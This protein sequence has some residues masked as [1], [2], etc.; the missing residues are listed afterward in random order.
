[1]IPAQI[2]TDGH[3]PAW[4]TLPYHVLLQIF[5]YA[6]HPLHDENMAPTLSIAWLSQIARM[7][8]AFTKPALTALYRNPPIFA[9]KH[10]RKDL[11]Q[12]LATPPAETYVDYRVMVK[13]LELDATQMASLTDPTHNPSDLAS[14]IAALTTVKEIDIFDPFDRPPYRARAKRVRRWHYPD[15]LFDALRQS[16][17]RLWSWRWNNSFCVGGFLRI[18]EIH[19]ATTF[20]SLRELTLTKFAPEKTRKFGDDD[21]GDGKPTVE[22]LLATALVALPNLRYLTFESCDVVNERLL[23]LLPVALRSLN[24]INCIYLT[25]D[26]LQ[27]CLVEHGQHLEELVLNHNQSLNLSFLVDLKLSCPRLEVLRMDLNYYSSLVMSSDNEP[28]YDY[29]LAVD[30][31]P[32]WP[33]TLRVIDM[34]YL[35]HWSP[36]AATNFFSSLIESSEDLAELRE[37]RIL[38]MVDIDWRQRADF[39]RK[40]AARFIKVFARRYVPPSSHLVSL[41]AYREWKASQSDD[42]EKHD[43]LLDMSEEVKGD[44][45]ASDSDA[46]LMARRKQKHNERWNSDRLRSR[47]QA[48]AHYDETSDSTSVSE[49]ASTADDKPDYIQGCCHTVTFRIDNLRP[50]EDLYDEGDFLDEERSGDEDW[51][52]NDVVEDDYAW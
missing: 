18:K 52:G 49:E 7:C 35:R 25:S 24:I 26:A 10:N 23:P 44:G 4:T 41:R 31:I 12:H 48:S 22:E 2:P 42:I 50:R 32:T 19:E 11:V 3:R 27:A 30:E 39:R 36:T 38:A 21:D 45:V 5:V 15:E 46:P 34:E 51:T 8:S 16:E 13:R 33:S 14:L 20:Q 1:M 17:V 9:M 47:A 37:L 40:W 6:S 29:L 43:S 28:I